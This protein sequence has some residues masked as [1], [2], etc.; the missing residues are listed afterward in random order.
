LK[1]PYVRLTKCQDVDTMAKPDTWKL[2]GWLQS[3][4]AD[5]YPVL[6]LLTVRD[7]VRSSGV[8]R[9]AKVLD[10]DEETGFFVTED[11]VYHIEKLPAP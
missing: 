7:G 4:I 6:I 5:G 3:E 11:D 9:T 2:E 1:T 10:Y 8:F